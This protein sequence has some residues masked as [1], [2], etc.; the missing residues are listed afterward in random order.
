MEKNILN[1]YLE[2]DKIDFK[3]I[4]VHINKLKVFMHPVRYAIMLLL[5][6]YK[7]M[8]VTDLYEKLSMKQAPVSNHLKLMKDNKILLTKR[9]GQ[10]IYYS[11]NEKIVK[12][13]FECMRLTIEDE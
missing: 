13:L 6:K 2:N 7:K 5:I 1:D 4:N 9:D 12:T 10:K 11:V 8:T 3:K